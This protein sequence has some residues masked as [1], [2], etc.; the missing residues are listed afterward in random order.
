MK[1]IFLLILLTIHLFGNNVEMAKDLFDN[2]EKHKEAIEIFQKFPDDAESEY[3]LGKAYYY[4]IGVNKDLKKAFEFAKK[5]ADK[6]NSSGLNLLGVIYQYGEGV[7]KD[8]SKAFEYYK[9]STDLGNTKAMRN[10]ASLYENGE[11]VKQDLSKA[12]ELYQKLIDLNDKEGYLGFASIYTYHQYN[13]KEALKYYSTFESLGGKHPNTFQNMAVIYRELNNTEK[14]IE[15]HRKASELGNDHSMLVLY[16]LLQKEENIKYRLNKNEHFDSLIKSAELGNKNAIL[17]IIYDDE[18]HKVISDEE[19][20]LWMKKGVDL[21]LELAY[22]PMYGYYI[23]KSDYINLKKFLE[24]SYYEDKN[25]EMGCYLSSYYSNILL[26]YDVEKQN[27]NK[28]YELIN[29]IISKYPNNEKISDCYLN[30]A[31]LYRHGKAVEKNDDKALEIYKQIQ[32]N[33]PI[34]YIQDFVTQEI[35]EMN[36]R[37]K[38][39]KD[40][41]NDPKNTSIKD[42]K[43]L[44]TFID[45][46]SKVDQLVTVLTSS[47]YYFL[48]TSDKSIKIVDKKTLNV[49]KELRGYIANGIDGI[50]TSMAY[51]E[52]NKLLYCA[53]VNSTKNYILNDIIK[54]YDIT[55]GKI[56]KT[57]QNKKSLKN[58]FLNISDDGKY[59]IAINNQNL[60]NYINIETNE[61]MHFNFNGL[62]K[63]IFANIEKKDS[64]YLIHLVSKEDKFYTISTNKNKIILEE[65]FNNQ[66]D[67]K[68]KTYIPII[69]GYKILNNFH[70]FN[71]IN[72]I[73][74]SNNSLQIEINDKSI[75]NFKANNLNLQGSFKEE[76]IYDSISINYIDD[77][78]TLEILKNNIKIG[79]INLG[80]QKISY[81]KV[82]DNKY[83]FIVSTDLLFQGFYDLKGNPLLML[84]GVLSLQK[85]LIFNK[86]YLIT[87]GDDNIVHIWDKNVLLNSK[88]NQDLYDENIMDMLS[89]TIGGNPSEMFEREYSSEDIDLLIKNQ[90]IDIN[91]KYNSE[92]LKSFLKSFMV[93]KEFIKPIV[94]IYIKNKND[95]IMYTPE[96]LFTYG[97][98]GKDLLKYHKNQGLYKE[99]K[100]IENDRLFEKFYRPDLIKRILAGEKVEIPMDVKS[101]ILNI[102]P[103][104]LK[105]LVNKMINTKDIELTYQVCDAG[106]GI[107]DAKLIINGQSI[108]P[109]QSRGFSIEQID[110]Q[111]DKCK[112]YKSVHTLFPGKS[113]IEFKA[114]D[115][116]MNIANVSDKLEVTADYKIIEKSKNMSIDDIKKLEN[117]NNNIVLEK[118]NLYF[119]SLAVAEYEDKNYNLKYTVNDVE[120]VKEK[121]VKNSKN[122]FENIFTYKL[123][124]NEVTKDNI[125]NIFDEISGKLKLNDTFVLYIAGHGTVQDGKYQFIPYKIDEKISIDNIKQNL[126]KI[127]NYTNKSLVMLD[128]CYSGAVIENISD[129]ATTNRLSHD[130]NSINYIVASSSEQVA[131]EGYN[132]HGI[133]TYSVLDAFDKNDKLKVKDL[134]DYV[135]QVVPKITQEKF[136][137][138]QTPQIKLNK[139]FILRGEN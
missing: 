98:I 20:L 137:Y 126:A 109:P 52:K 28:S 120:S 87:Y 131:L 81:H 64:D 37:I 32:Q 66:I 97:G 10:L 102:M 77:T 88:Y 58:T 67:I 5:S 117:E 17:E 72:N 113:T 50:V 60:L 138:S 124:D 78:S 96:G 106:N 108:N 93:K 121:F 40:I 1:K 42:E 73:S 94:S 12:K 75:F 26:E 74:Y 24:K 71:S 134:S 41:E 35:N 139:N 125:D 83:I 119:L 69:E 115:K 103:P 57:I 89:Y 114:Y 101:V 48:S 76:P 54:V 34:K 56:V 45:N 51:D 18:L 43:N 21:K 128:T 36:I 129:N 63:F 33:Y 130:N 23:D 99:A 110:N 59:L 112:I 104:E 6:N 46:F 2:K 3:Y 16:D 65:P 85:N 123:Q 15:Y 49:I 133:F 86:N 84:D 92:K 118:S 79:L 19:L 53:G 122:T 127:A 38:E 80:E 132:N 111:N 31:Y 7:E 135:T 95:W 13:S 82:I 11:Y 107:A 30:L 68:S 22:I 29:E 14:E 70:E 62:N 8:E 4:G 55:T 44:Y 91:Y 136:H 25:L 9:Q 47:N 61:I 116:D 100:I 105:I 27:F 90:F 39:T